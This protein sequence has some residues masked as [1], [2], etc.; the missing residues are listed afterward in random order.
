MFLPWKAHGVSFFF[1]G[2]EPH[3]FWHGRSKTALRPGG[4]GSLD[5]LM[6]YT[7]T[8]TS[9]EETFRNWIGMTSQTLSIKTESLEVV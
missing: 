3:C 1:C 6:I 7:P 5:S 9:F 8:H 2:L 4:L